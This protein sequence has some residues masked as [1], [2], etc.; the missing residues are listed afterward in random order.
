MSSGSREEPERRDH[1]DLT[2]DQ[3]LRQPASLPHSPGRDDALLRLQ[4]SFQTRRADLEGRRPPAESRLG[5]G[6]GG[7]ASLGPRV[8]VGAGGDG[9][10]LRHLPAA[11][12]RRRGGGA[13]GGGGGAERRFR[14]FQGADGRRVEP[15]E[16][17]GGVRG[18]ER[19]LHVRG[20]E[21]GRRRG[22]TAV[23]ML[24]RRRRRRRRQHHNIC[25][26]L[27]HMKHET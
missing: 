22:G 10:V 1:P 8:K 6:G 13:G 15:F 5:G 2:S 19:R 17:G 3:Q 25:R 18:G 16:V 7:E 26:Q 23:M 4:E 14:S 12:R 27:Q 9:V 20:A 24:Q 11:A 21:G